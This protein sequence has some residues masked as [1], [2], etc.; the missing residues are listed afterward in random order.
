MRSGLTAILLAPAA[1]ALAASLAP[2]QATTT[3][4]TS[5]ELPAT[6]APLGWFNG[7]GNPQGGFTVVTED[8]IELGLRA[9][10][11]QSPNVIDSPNNIY[12]VHRGLQNPGHAL[13]NY[14]YSVDLGPDGG[15]RTL[16]DVSITLSVAKNGGPASTVDIFAL[17]AD[18]SYFGASGKIDGDPNVP[19]P[20]IPDYWALQNSENPLFSNFPLG[21]YNPF[22]LATYSFTLSVFDDQQQLL[23]SNSIDVDVVPEPAT[24]LL[25]GAGLA[26]LGVLRR[27]RAQA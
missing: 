1:L 2:A 22:E 27:R 7:S 25:F 11:R 8:S 18:N 13:W 6:G 21:G 19:D 14:E 4:D 24:L 15:G 16:G 10:L 20:N 23:A 17:A 5:L 12:T 26:G 9:K 3:F